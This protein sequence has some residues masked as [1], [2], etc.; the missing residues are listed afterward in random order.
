MRIVILAS[1]NGTNAEAIMRASEHEHFA[2][3]VVAVVSD[4]GDAGVVERAERWGV[5][6]VVVEKE[7]TE[8]REAY[9]ARLVQKVLLHQ[10]NL[11]VLAGWMRVLTMSFIGTCSAPII[12]L[13]P[14][15]PGDLP[16][17]N[18][19]ERAFLEREIGRTHSG[20]M[21]HVVP[22]EGVDTGPV[23]ASRSVGLLANDTFEIFKQRMQEAEHDLIVRVVTDVVT[24]KITLIQGAHS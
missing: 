8:T 7:S 11:V 2:G 14:A 13:H 4:H 24:K 12:N 3:D 20:V 9:D 21:V 17:I 19:I 16:G 5:P 22:D 18:A 23:V 10:P 1:G 15:L 6:S